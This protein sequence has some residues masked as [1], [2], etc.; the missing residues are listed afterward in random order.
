MDQA[1]YFDKAVSESGRKI[2]KVIYVNISEEETV[3]R[4][5][6]RWICEK[7]KKV[8][9][10]GKDI[11]S[12]KESCPDCQGKIIQRID[13]T[14]EVIRKRLKVFQNETIPVIEH[15]KKQEKLTE[16]NGEQTIEKVFEGILAKLKDIE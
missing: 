4:I 13:D 6:K 9:I 12:E 7:C 15:Y 3:K 1:E 2:D 14:P 11:K 5:S 10:K 8:L 16:V